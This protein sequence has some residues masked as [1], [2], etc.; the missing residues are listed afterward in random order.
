MVPLAL[1]LLTFVLAFREGSGRWDAWL[2]RAHV[3]GVGI[4]FFSI[5]LATSQLWWTLSAHLGAFL[6]AAFACH[7]ALYRSRPASAHLTEFYLY[8]SL[9]GMIGGL[10]CGL[11]APYVFSNVVEYPLAL[12]LS[13]L[14]VPLLRGESW[15]QSWEEHRGAVLI[16]LALV[17]AGLGI[18]VFDLPIDK[19]F[20]VMVGSF[21]AAT[22]LVWRATQ[23]ML[24]LALAT[25]IVIIV[26]P[27]SG[28]GRETIRSFFGVH[29]IVQLD[30]G[31]FRALMHGTTV[32][33]AMRIKNPDGTPY[34]GRPEPTTYYAFDGAIGD[35][36]A[37]I[38][39][40]RGGR[41]GAVAAIGL[42]TGSL[43]CHIRPGEASTYYEIDP[44]VVRIAREPR[45]FRFLSDCA[46][47]LP[48]VLGDARLKI[49][50]HPGQADLIV[51]DAFSSDAI[52]THLMTREAIR[53]YAGKL[54]PTG[55][56]LF[57]ISNRHMDLSKVLAATA[58][59]EGFQ[60]YLR[61]DEADEGFR[62]RFKT[63][64]MVAVLA[65][66]AEDVS[67]LAGANEWRRIEPPAGHKPWT[68]DYANILRAIA[69]HHVGR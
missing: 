68:D 14:A 39:E 47:D 53:L 62:T 55:A 23:P 3:W 19:P 32:H 12:L 21:A 11:I 20:A 18:I 49:T 66:R 40:S 1:Y 24:A 65:R 43:A 27:G 28:G 58:A 38:R 57:H 2:I 54:A 22:M 33:G 45:Y 36:I 63:P 13:L 56:A 10:F 31:R 25:M 5:A 29:K 60:L 46:P 16:G 44:D 42:G 69:D 9:G 59:A 67:A 61:H 64:A 48:I 6:A 35:G 17:F 26:V 8:I 30:N 51:V 7:L 50:G 52:P 34:E 37:K 15:R 4:A 41:L